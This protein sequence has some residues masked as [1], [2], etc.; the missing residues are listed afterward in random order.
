MIKIA[1][2]EDDNA[3]TQKFLDYIKRYSEESKEEINVVCFTDGDEIASDYKPVYD[4]IFL[5]IEMKRLNGMSAAEHIR[6][7]D[8]DVIIIFITNMAQ[9][10]IKGYSVGALDY[11]LK[12]VPYFAFSQQ[13]KRS[14][15]KVKAKDS[16]YLLINLEN[17]ILKLPVR[18]ILF[19]ESMKHKMIIHCEDNEYEI[20]STMKE[21]EDK[22]KPNNFFRCNNCY[23]V[24]LAYI[25][26][27]KDNLALIG[28]Y[29][30][31][32]SRPRKKEFLEALTA[33]VGGR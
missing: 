20:F 28:K 8:Q 14:I 4:I 26:G 16:T 25:S 9:Y 1:I 2:V 30:L 13:L 5:D 11:L 17:G 3:S 31:Q 12:P 27:I 29:E 18:N 19:I 24:N 22:L 15:E 33:Y 23:L 21:L 10:A 32:I 6:K 7:F